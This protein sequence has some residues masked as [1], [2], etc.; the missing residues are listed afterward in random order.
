ML[1]V[2]FY[3]RLQTHLQ[4]R[5]VHVQYGILIFTQYYSYLLNPF[6]LPLPLSLSLSLSLSF[7]FLSLPLTSS[8][9]SLSSLY[10]LVRTL[11]MFR[12]F[13]TCPLGM[14]SLAFTGKTF[15][16]TTTPAVSAQPVKGKEGVRERER[17]M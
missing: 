5:C 14:R 13:V 9:L 2:L 11:L 6:Y 4:G 12:S 8:S 10:P 17:A 16:A 1:N 15:S 3:C 7:T